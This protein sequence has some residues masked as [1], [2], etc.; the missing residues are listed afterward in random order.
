[1]PSDE[2]KMFEWLRHQGLDHYFINFIQSEITDI[3][4][5]SRLNLPDEEIYDEL[6]IT[7]PGH[8]RRLE[9]AG[10]YLTDSHDLEHR[11]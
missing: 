6:E 11:V 9:R 1:M 8:K 10:N 3:E 7:L 2:F 4:Q 5:I